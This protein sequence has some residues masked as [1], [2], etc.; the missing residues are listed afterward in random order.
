MEF[1]LPIRSY[2]GLYWVS[3]KGNVKNKDDKILKA[4][5]NRSRRHVTLCK[6]DIRELCVMY[7]LVAQ[8]FIPNSNPNVNTVVHHIDDNSQNDNVDNLMWCTQKYNISE[9]IAIKK[10]HDTMVQ[11][12][13]AM[14]EQ[15]KALNPD[16][17]YIRG[18][19]NSRTKCLWKCKTCDNKWMATPDHVKRGSG[20]FKCAHK[21]LITSQQKP[22]EQRKNKI[23]VETFFSIA[24]ASNN[25]GIS[26]QNI[27]SCLHG[28]RTSTGGYQWSFK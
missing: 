28:K 19:Y 11:G 5:I 26:R 22:V 6:D 10:L 3:N 9:P 1:W 16:V 25:T 20:C 13:Q 12:E 24:D 15:T 8:A 23:V 7:R 18:F 4:Y 17:S 27:S 14:V 21:K 2:E